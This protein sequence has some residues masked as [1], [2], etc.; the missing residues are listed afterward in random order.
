MYKEV[1]QNSNV[2]APG[3]SGFNLGLLEKELPDY[4]WFEARMSP[5]N[6]SIITSLLL[7]IISIMMQIRDHWSNTNCHQPSVEMAAMVSIT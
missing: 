6:W 3:D 4:L 5:A 2:N 7:A 1:K